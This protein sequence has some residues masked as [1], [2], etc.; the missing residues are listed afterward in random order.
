MLSRSL[1]AIL[2]L[3]LPAVAVSADDSGK[4]SRID[5][6]AKR[7]HRAARTAVSSSDPDWRRVSVRL[8]ESGGDGVAFWSAAFESLL[9]NEVGGLQ[10]GDGGEPA[11]L[12][13]GTEIPRTVWALVHGGVYSCCDGRGAGYAVGFGG[14]VSL[15]GRVRLLV[16]GNVMGEPGYG[17]ALYVSSTL[18]YQFADRAGNS[19]LVGIGMGRWEDSGRQFV[20][21]LGGRTG[22]GQVRVFFPGH[23]TVVL[24]LGGVRF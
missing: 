14:D 20:F 13:R 2:L 7:V 6:T 22:F 8:G 19:T 1:L 18:A 24:L 21:G 4:A 10:P 12:R 5:V 16:D 3:K 23:E 17:N 15:S 11:A 9:N